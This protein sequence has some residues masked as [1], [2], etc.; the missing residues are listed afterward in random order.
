MLNLDTLNHILDTVDHLNQ[1]FQIE[2]YP[3]Y[4]KNIIKTFFKDNCILGCMPMSNKTDAVTEYDPDNGIYVIVVNKNKTDKSMLKRLNFTLAH[5]LGHIVLK[6]EPYF[7]DARN[8]SPEQLQQFEDEADEFAGQFL[9]PE[10]I[11]NC[12]PKVSIM[13]DRFFVST[14]AAEKRLQVIR[15]RQYLTSLRLRNVDGCFT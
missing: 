3:I 13:R 11:V 1:I 14:A 10:D 7:R 12:F 8:L 2:E 5:E 15:N 9:M 6:H 4:T